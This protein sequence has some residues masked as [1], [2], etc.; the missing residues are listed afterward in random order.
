ML[1]K[2]VSSVDYDGPRY[3]PAVFLSEGVHVTLVIVH[4]TVDWLHT[5]IVFIILSEQR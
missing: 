4:G 2:M 1:I 5:L 3:L